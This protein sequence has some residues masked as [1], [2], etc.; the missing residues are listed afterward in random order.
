M[1]PGMPPATE[2][3]ALDRDGYRRNVG[4]VV[5]N[6]RRQVLWARR[7]RH[8]GWQFPQG[9]IQ[10]HESARAAAFRELHEEVGLQA[11]HVRLLGATEQWLKYEVPAELVGKVGK[12]E[13]CARPFRGQKQRWFLFQLISQESCV[14]LDACERP[15]F[16]RWQWVDYWQPLQQVVE[17]KRRVYQQALTELEPLLRRMSAAGV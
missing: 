17:F 4:I 13:A 16:D 2:S 3:Q 6:A 11:E 14:C 8:D 5:C 12:T 10:P 1:L 9:G 15:E 7:V